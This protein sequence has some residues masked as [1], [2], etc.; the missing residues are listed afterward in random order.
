MK[1]IFCILFFLSFHS[2]ADLTEIRKTY[3]NASGSLTAAKEF[4]SKFFDVT[5]DNNKTLVAYKGASIIIVSKFETKVSDKMQGVKQGIK[6]IEFA[7]GIESNNIEIRLIRLSIQENLPKI[8]KYN[9]NKNEDKAFLL[10]HYKEQPNS[11]KDYVKS[12]ILQSKS[13]SQQE[14]QALN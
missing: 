12:F 1:S 4:N 8:A 13:F 10:S 3:H 2:N 14:K 7:I 11:L 6:L 9:K 5:N